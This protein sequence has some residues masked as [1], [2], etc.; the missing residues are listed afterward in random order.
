MKLEESYSV[1]PEE[2]IKAYESVPTE[3][4]ACLSDMGVELSDSPRQI[5]YGE[6]P[7]N[8]TLPRDYYTFSNDQLAE[9]MSVH[10]EWTRYVQGL[11]AHV[12]NM[13]RIATEKRAAA[14]SAI[15]KQRSKE[16]VECDRRYIIANQEYSHWRSVKTILEAA[17]RGNSGVYQTLSR[18][19]TLRGQDQ[20][21]SS[22]QN[23]VSRGYAFSRG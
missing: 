9:L 22:R 3:V 6:L 15:I 16:V 20:E 19:I 4:S 17:D 1:T 5:M 14:K 18:T 11:L 23:S 8:G 7:Y 21:Q 10:N 13:F 2:A 12:E